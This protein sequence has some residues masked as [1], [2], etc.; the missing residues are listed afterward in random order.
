MNLSKIKFSKLLAF[1]I[2]S[3]C[4]SKKCLSQNLSKPSI[5]VNPTNS[6]AARKTK[7]FTVD[8]TEIPIIK[9]SS[10]TIYYPVLYPVKP[11]LRDEFYYLRNFEQIKNSLVL[12]YT[13]PNVLPRNPVNPSILLAYGKDVNKKDLTA[14]LDNTIAISSEDFIIS[15]SNSFIEFYDQN[16]SMVFRSELNKF[17]N[18]ELP[19]PCD[20]KVV[21]DPEANRFI[22]FL[23]RCDG[24]I[25]KSKIMVAFS[26]TSNPLDGWNFYML[27]GNPLNKKFCWFDYPKIALSGEDVFISG[28]IFNDKDFDQSVI[29]QINKANGYSGNKLDFRVWYDFAETPFTIK[30][31][32][33]SHGRASNQGIFLITTSWDING[34]SSNH[35][36]LY[37]ITGDLYDAQSK[38][39][40]FKVSVDPYRFFANAIQ[41]NKIIDN[42]DIRMQDALLHG[43]SIY[44]AFTS[45]N[46]NNFSRINF[47]VLDLNSLSNRSVLI[48]E[49]LNT[50]YAYPSIHFLSDENEVPNILIQYNSA[51][52]QSYPDIRATTC[53]DLVNC[54]EEVVLKKGESTIDF[55]NRWGDYTT[56]TKNF[57]TS[58][59]LYIVSSY[60]KSRLRQ[61]F[62]GKVVTPNYDFGFIDTIYPEDL[63][64]E[65]NLGFELRKEKNIEVFLRRG[66]DITKIYEGL[67][68]EGENQFQINTNKLKKGDYTLEVLKKNSSKTL[69]EINFVIQQ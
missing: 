5:G 20:P 6:N 53:D 55:N 10:D 14:P 22:L 67:A 40:Y 28:N 30:P 1:I 37:D 64:S 29:Y 49:N 36:K 18:Y 26:K 65:V 11:K 15:V 60:G 23:Q 32:G 61:S 46:G 7:I 69:N 39:N 12:N 43:N 13:Q 38:V 42:G 24:N 41:I 33:Y 66:E 63:N 45:G 56:V 3:F 52:R 51:S 2:I 17:V 16:K 44:Y 48:G 54:S 57:K 62:I 25:T 34:G 31:V 19:E 9:K 8:K 59:E 50:S 68:S 4:I 27:A 21:F 47:N 58:N 35:V